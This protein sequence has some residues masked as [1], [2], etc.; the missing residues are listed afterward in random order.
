[1]KSKNEYIDSL[2]SELKEWSAQIDQLAARADTA[3]DHAKVRYAAELEELRA[4]RRRASEHLQALQAASGDA[5]EN[6]SMNRLTRYG[7][8][9]APVW[10]MPCRN[11]SLPHRSDSRWGI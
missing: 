11:S 8:T 4:K 5:W 10:R 3:T 1:M 9:C 6:R 7:A 2:S